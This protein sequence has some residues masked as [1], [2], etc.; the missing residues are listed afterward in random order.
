MNMARISVFLIIVALAAGLMGCVGGDGNGDGSYTLIVDFT[1]GGTVT[2]DNMPISGKAILNY[3]PGTVVSLNAIPNDDYRFVNWTGNASTIDDANSAST[4]VTV[5]DDYYITANFLAQYMLTVASTEGGEV[6]IPGEGVFAY[7]AG[8]VVDLVAEA[9]E[10]YEFAEWTGDVGDIADTDAASTTIMTNGNYVITANFGPPTYES[11]DYFPIAEGYGI[12]Y[13]VTDNLDDP[14]FNVNVWAVSQYFET[15]K[16]GDLD[17]VFTVVK[18]GTAEEYYCP[19]SLGGQTAKP[20]DDRNFTT[21][22]AGFPVGNQG[23]F[24]MNFG[25]PCTFSFGDEWT[26]GD[27]QYAVE[28]SGQQTINGVDFDDCIKITIDDSLN[29]NEYMRGSGYF[30]LARDV[31]IV[32]LIFN[33]TDGTR[34]SY[35][36]REHKQLVRHTIS[37]SIREGGVPVEGLIVQISNGNW[38]T[39]S[40]TDSNGSFSVQAYG[41]DIVLRLGYDED[42]DDVFEFGNYADYPKE[43]S[44]NNVM[45]DIVGLSIDI[46]ML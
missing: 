42:D 14:P 36:Y 3:D 18:E 21:F 24:Y 27:R 1:A 19:C 13:H 33:R 12:K 22:C 35:E 4:T 28:Q 23:N 44:V 8:T 16:P 10:G 40:V 39:R 38:G 17:F 30:I 15:G 43:F 32:E 29:E 31:G 11:L 7:D 45:S 37:G 26:W 9:E 20:W 2:V 41:P 25:L 46:S 5:N 34:V 6:T